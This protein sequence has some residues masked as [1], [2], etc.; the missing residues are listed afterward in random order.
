MSSSQIRRYNQPPPGGN[1][2][3]PVVR[4]VRQITIV[5]WM[6]VKDVA[7]LFGVS[8]MTVYRLIHAE[9][10]PALKVGRSFR[11]R[12]ADAIRFLKENSTLAD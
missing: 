1:M 5:N 7:T 11:V 12:E 6:M 8:K 4:G 9:E 10:L 3:P 2:A